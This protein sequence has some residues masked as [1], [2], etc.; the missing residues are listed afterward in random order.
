MMRIILL[1]SLMGL[2]VSANK[3]D[4]KL[5]RRTKFEHTVEDL[6][7]IFSI[8]NVDYGLEKRVAIQ[9]PWLLKSIVYHNFHITEF[10]HMDR[11][12]EIKL[13]LPEDYP[14]F[15]PDKV[16]TMDSFDDYVIKRMRITENDLKGQR[17][18]PKQETVVINYNDKPKI[19]PVIPSV[20]I[21]PTSKNED[22]MS[23]EQ[24]NLESEIEEEKLFEDEE[25]LRLNDQVI[26]YCVQTPTSLEELLEVEFKIDPKMEFYNLYLA[27][28]KG[29]N[30]HILDFSQISEKTLVK[31]MLPLGKT[32]NSKLQTN[33]FF[34]DKVTDKETTLKE[35]IKEKLG[36]QIYFIDNDTK[37]ID[38]IKK[39]NPE[40]KFWSVIGPGVKIKLYIPMAVANSCSDPQAKAEKEL[41]EFKEIVKKEKREITRM[42]WTGF[43]M[44]STGS[45]V[46]V[47]DGVTLRS[48]QN[49][50]ITLGTSFNYIQ[51]P[52]ERF[53][54]SLYMSKLTA[55]SSDEQQVYV[56]SEFGV[57]AYYEKPKAFTKMG[58]Y[59]GYDYEAFSTFN[60]DELINGADIEVRE[61]G[62]HY[63]TGGLSFNFEAF[64]R[65]VFA[66]TSF[67][68]SMLS[69]SSAG[70]SFTGFKTM[71]FLGTALNEQWG[72]NVLWKRHQLAGATSLV[73]S[74]LG[75][76]VSLSF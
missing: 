31:V 28:V 16:I 44:S 40:I 36:E 10:R 27:R 53:S 60:T 24:P 45:F 68:Y 25:E 30:D 9:N 64:K 11:G 76:G 29:I 18:K 23:V 59:Y 33:K 3:Y 54:A 58:Y 71:F 8:L 63:L 22:M 70:T 67:S 57:T 72:I 15:N 50:P 35:F 14:Q 66:R 61:Q 1:L 38:D 41:K 48:S 46:E 2:L 34:I 43:A 13:A 42:K 4:E 19:S 17:K 26:F 74:R 39:L 55:M 52:E 7:D 37:Y 47:K 51:S 5:R 32:Y 73:I 65:P 12:I 20:A 6:H 69:T 56:P 62:I 75:V 21:D 49:S